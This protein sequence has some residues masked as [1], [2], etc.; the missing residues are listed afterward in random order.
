MFSAFDNSNI[1]ANNG[2][3]SLSREEILNS[4]IKDLHVYV[5]PLNFVNDV[6]QC[7]F[8]KSKLLRFA[9]AQN[10]NHTAV[11]IRTEDDSLILIEY[12]AYDENTDANNSQRFNY[13]KRRDGLRFIQISETN[14]TSLITEERSTCIQ[15]F[16]RNKMSIKDLLCITE[17]IDGPNKW[18]KNSYNLITHNCQC[19]VKTVLKILGA[20][21]EASNF[22][23][24]IPAIIQVELF[25]NTN[26][27]H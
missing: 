8:Y 22:L 5:T 10:L 19:F 12:G 21:T 15:C 23:N 16:I 27:H 6:A 26:L 24:K 1:L 14:F 4:M 20:T 17:I 7:L 11:I 9:A 18:D 2:L 25:K 13:Y 3:V